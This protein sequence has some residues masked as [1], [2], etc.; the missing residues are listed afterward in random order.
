MSISGVCKCMAEMSVCEMDVV[1]VKTTHYHT[2]ITS[3]AA[4]IPTLS[5][6]EERSHRS[7]PQ[8]I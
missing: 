6:M 3:V 1:N 5:H 2:H 4:I 7:L 8:I